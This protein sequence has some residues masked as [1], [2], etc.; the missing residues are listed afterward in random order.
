M[1]YSRGYTSLVKS[2]STTIIFFRSWSSSQH[3]LFQLV[4]M[5][6]SVLDVITRSVSSHI[7]GEANQ[8]A[9][10]FAKV[11][12]SMSFCSRNFHVPNFIIV[13]FWADSSRTSFP[14][15]F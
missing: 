12:L 9:D 15:D 11:G 7:R 10:G 6:Q 2:D 5:V 1:S 4:F 13:A 3:P 14:M 8:V